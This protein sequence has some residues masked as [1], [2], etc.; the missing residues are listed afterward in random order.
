MMLKSTVFV[1]QGKL[2]V[3]VSNTLINPQTPSVLTKRLKIHRSSIARVLSEL[4]E[5]GL[6]KY[7]TP[8]TNKFALYGLTKLGKK[9]HKQIH[10]LGLFDY[11]LNENSDQNA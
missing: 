4:K 11:L 7:L 8:P 10:K 9:T 6:I 1:S 3:T 2:R 5:A